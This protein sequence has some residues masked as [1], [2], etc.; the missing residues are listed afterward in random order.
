MFNHLGRLLKH[1]TVYGL[2]ETISRGTGFILL[3]LYLLLDPVAGV[4]DVT[5]HQERHVALHLGA[6]QWVQKRVATGGHLRGRGVVVA[7]GRCPTTTTRRK[8]KGRETNEGGGVH[9][10]VVSDD[11][12][13]NIIDT[14]RTRMSSLATTIGWSVRRARGA[15]ASSKSAPSAL[16]A[17][18]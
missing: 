8:K 11:D 13:A 16:A 1:S 9:L 15:R 6:E 2:A 5:A 18:S 3:F 17:R 7:A 10:L 4:L 14:R 12:A